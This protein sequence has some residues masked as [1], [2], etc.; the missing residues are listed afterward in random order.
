LI[1]PR[2]LGLLAL[3]V[4]AFGWGLGWLAMK[5]VL[6]TWTPLFSRGL[7]GVVSA[8][9]IAVVARGRGESLAVRPRAA[10]QLALAAF[11]NVFAWM[12]FSALCLRWLRVG[13]GVLLV[14]T[15][16]MWA[17]L[18]AWL[19]L[20]TRPTSRGFA[21]LAHKVHRSVG[22]KIA[23]GKWGAKTASNGSSWRYFSCGAACG[24]LP[25]VR[26]EANLSR[27]RPF[28]RA[29]Q[30]WRK[31]IFDVYLP[32]PNYHWQAAFAASSVI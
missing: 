18:F 3:F 29:R 8:A 10:P 24:Q 30:V 31:A 4:T 16:P 25:P 19:L 28:A 17:T 12:G 26:P 5:L 11:T 6:Q 2:W 9:L 32:N 20:G 7:A 15:M 22:Q 21:A 23:T 1:S 27:Y 14:F 13:E